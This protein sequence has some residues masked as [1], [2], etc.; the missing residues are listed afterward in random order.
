M[1]NRQADVFYCDP[2]WGAGTLKFFENLRAKQ[3]NIQSTS[4]PEFDDFITKFFDVIDRWAKDLVFIEYGKK[5]ANLILEKSLARGLRHHKT[6]E[7][8]YRS[9]AKL[10]PSHLHA[11][12][13]SGSVQLAYLDQLRHLRGAEL[14]TEALRPHISPGNLILD[15]CCGCGFTAAAALELNADFYG[16]EINEVRLAKTIRRFK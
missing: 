8:Q 13:K 1:Q 11:L 2:P 16:N 4:I 10:L 9:G 5:W 3:E 6:I 12:S 7:V 14:V 15:P